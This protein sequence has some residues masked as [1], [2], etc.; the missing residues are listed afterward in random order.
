MKDKRITMF[1]KVLLTVLNVSLF[2]WVWIEYYNDI[3]YHTYLLRGNIMSILIFYVIYIWLA[4]LYRA[5]SIASSTVEETVLS[6]FISF[7]IA[8]LVLYITAVLLYR[9]YVNIWPGAFIVA[10][11]LI[12]STLIVWRSKK[13]MMGH[14]QPSSV[15]LVCG[16]VDEEQKA[17]FIRQLEAKLPHLFRLDSMLTEDQI[18][19]F[20]AR[21]EDVG[22]VM[23]MGV[24]TENRNRLV[25]LCL[26]HR[27]EFFFVPDFVDIICRGC[28][29]KN[30]VDTPLLRYDYNYDRYR[31]LVVKRVFDIV[32]S[33]ILLV[34]LSPVFLISAIAIKLEDRGPVFFFQDRVTRDGRVFRIIK[35]RSMIVDAEAMGAQPATQND[36]R[37]TKVGAIMRKYRIDEM[38]QLINILLGHMSFVGPRPERTL[39]ERLYEEHLPEFKFR[40]RVKG[41]LTGYAQVYGKYNTSPEDKLKLDM[42]YIENQSLVL[43]FKLILLTIKIMF[44]PESTEGF[45]SERS[46]RINRMDQ[47]NSGGL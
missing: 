35:F 28:L 31:N 19:D 15:L 1:A 33:A 2:A 41:G 5:F 13:Y 27:K 42:L 46:A 18:D 12:G 16:N 14:I 47:Q 39:H 32:L 40:L 17:H 4:K 10:C 45:D 8:D 7:G 11:Q 25:H 22:T 21:I 43:D 30:F 20:E 9:D 34:V 26:A 37:I 36:P 6:Q 44:K 38:P 23:L 29:I 24:S 3:A